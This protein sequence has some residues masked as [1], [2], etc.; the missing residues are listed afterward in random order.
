VWAP[1]DRRRLWIGEER[2]AHGDAAARARP[3][4]DDLRLHAATGRA[5]TSLEGEL[6]GPAVAVGVDDLR[7]RHEV[8]LA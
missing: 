6:V 3:E 8:H 5:R 7:E 2:L 1:A 4:G